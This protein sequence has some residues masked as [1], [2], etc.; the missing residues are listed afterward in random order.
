VSIPDTVCK[1]SKEIKEEYKMSS[2]NTAVLT[3]L[4]DT[5][6]KTLH[7]PIRLE[8][9]TVTELDTIFSGNKLCQLWTKAQH[10]GDH[11]R[12]HYQ[13]NDIIPLMMEAE[14]VSEMLGFC[15]QLS[16]FPEKILLS[17]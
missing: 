12:L 14:M 9:F 10:F 17:S 15:P 2:P 7:H 5:K 13:G 11:I 4:E 3:Y 6:N 1:Q 8:C 16:L